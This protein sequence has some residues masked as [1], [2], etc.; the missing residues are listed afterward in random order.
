MEAK[1]TKK[2]FFQRNIYYFVLAFALLA[3]IALTLYLALYAG[4]NNSNVLNSSGGQVE[5]VPKNSSI[6]L[7][8]NDNSN[9][10]NTDSE[11]DGPDGP[12][13][14][15]PDDG[16]QN[17]PVQTV[18][19]FVMP[20]E[21]ATVICDYTATS[22]VYNQTLNIYNGHLAIDFAADMGSEVKAVYGGK[23]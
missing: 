5:E 3:V 6:T 21:N 12:T 19:S 4:N 9:S 1:K 11:P 10:G 14:G 13:D 23:I 2:N 7:P 15:E 22:V 18:V 20:V 17:Q 8:P 16:E